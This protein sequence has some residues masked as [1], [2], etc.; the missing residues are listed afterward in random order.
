MYSVGLV[1]RDS[2]DQRQEDKEKDAPMKSD[3]GFCFMQSRCNHS[4]EH[5]YNPRSNKP[6]G[7]LVIPYT[8]AYSGS[9]NEAEREIHTRV[10]WLK[11][12]IGMK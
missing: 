10:Y 6:W 7:V 2:Y 11:G 12:L 3:F 8:D 9:E 5:R 4:K 1:S